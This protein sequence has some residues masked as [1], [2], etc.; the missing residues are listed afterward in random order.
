VR[1]KKPCRRKRV[2]SVSS[3]GSYQ[4]A[5]GICA[6]L[7]LEG[8]D[9][10]KSKKEQHPAMRPIDEEYDRRIE[11]GIAIRRGVV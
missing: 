6:T 9:S 8:A 10:P 11:V 5:V 2:V 3:W 7:V 4:R 1:I